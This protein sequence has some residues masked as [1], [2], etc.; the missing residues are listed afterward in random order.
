MPNCLPLSGTQLASPLLWELPAHYLF[1]SGCPA[2]SAALSHWPWIRLLCMTWQ[3][4]TC[5]LRL[6]ETPS[7]PSVSLS[8]GCFPLLDWEPAFLSTFCC[9]IV[10]ACG[11]LH[12]WKCVCM[13]QRRMC[14]R[15]N[16]LTMQLKSTAYAWWCK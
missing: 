5:F 14:S 12:L 7:C 2:A 11:C 15:N 16:S 13:C 10:C 9:L 6:L 4:A 3:H 8:E 1:V